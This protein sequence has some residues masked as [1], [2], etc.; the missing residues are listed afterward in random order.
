MQA[1][2]FSP[3][4]HDGDGVN[5]EVLRQLEL[6]L[7]RTAGTDVALHG[8]IGR[9]R[10]MILQHLE[11]DPE[12]GYCQGMTLVAAVFA[13]AH[14]DGE[15]EAYRRFAAFVQ[16]VRGLWLPGSWKGKAAMG[17]PVTGKTPPLECFLS[18]DP[19]KSVNRMTA[20]PKRVS[21]LQA[22]FVLKQFAEFALSSN[23]LLKVGALEQMSMLSA[24]EGA[25]A[26]VS[27]PSPVTSAAESETS[28]T[29]RAA[30]VPP[31][32]AL[33]GF[34]NAALA[35]KARG[36]SIFRR[37]GDGDE[38][39]GS[40]KKLSTTFCNLFAVWLAIAAVAA[41]KHPASFTWVKS[42][43]FTGLLGLLMFSVGI[44]TTIDDFRECLKRPGAVAINFISCYGIMPCLAFILAK[45]IGAE[46][47]ILAGLVLV[48]SIN[49]GQASNLCTLIAGGDVALSVL[50]T[51]S[52]TLGCIF[53]TPLICKLVLGAVVPVDA[54][55]IVVS[56]FQVVLAPIFLGAVTP[57]TPVVGVVSTVLLVGASVA[58]CAAPIK[59]AGIPL[60]VACCALHL[61]G[62]LLG[63][64]ATKAAGFNERTCRTG[65]RAALRP[66]TFA[67]H[68]RS[69][70]SGWPSSEVCWPC[71]GRAS[72]RPTRE[73]PNAA[74]LQGLM[75]LRSERPG[76]PLLQPSIASFEDRLKCHPALA[77]GRPWFTHLVRYGVQ[78]EMF[79]PQALLSML[80]TWLPHCLQF[81]ESGLKSLLSLA[82]ALLDSQESQLLQQQ[83]FEEGA[84]PERK[85]MG[86]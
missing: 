58:K 22:I 8:C 66:S 78:T 77:K 5:A 82:V 24:K 34:A 29:Q 55:G 52:T 35:R 86:I 13:A 3:S 15:V 67:F 51:T 16:R 32:V 65:D 46:G 40:F 50:M 79:L 10:K 56:T 9:V 84:Q 7:P 20:D 21:Q 18:L 11:D 63:F 53:M 75:T 69:A 12:L 28:A 1:A 2:P 33:W 19:V 43:Y 57:F 14:N 71:T 60:Q 31:L 38:E 30:L 83:S 80:V 54:G 36:R 68:P 59:G 70:W 48:G 4:R 42:E 49:G 64:F 26:A 73:W 81:L 44:T 76:F 37:A 39:E 23:Q 17:K 72:R 62:G 61:F 6:D 27:M 25:S 47:A 45:L 41:L 85:T 74:D